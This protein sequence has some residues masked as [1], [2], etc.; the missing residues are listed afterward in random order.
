M[1][2]RFQKAELSGAEFQAVVEFAPIQKTPHNVKAKVDARQGTIDTGTWL[3]LDTHAL[4]LRIYR[5]GLS[6][7]SG[8]SQESC[9][10]ACCRHRR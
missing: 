4:L 7:I 5:A 10:K 1:S 6:L 8:N 3:F 9:G 2:M